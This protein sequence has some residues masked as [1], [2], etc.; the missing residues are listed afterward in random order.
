MG[1]TFNDAISC[2][3][4]PIDLFTRSTYT[5]VYIKVINLFSCIVRANT[6]CTVYLVPVINV[7]KE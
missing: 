6:T 5:R 4:M 1:N 2:L 3:E 7:L